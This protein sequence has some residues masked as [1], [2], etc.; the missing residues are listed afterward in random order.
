MKERESLFSVPRKVLESRR[1]LLFAIV[2]IA[3]QAVLVLTAGRRA[4]AAFGFHMFSE[5][6]TLVITLSREIDGQI[7]PVVDG[8]WS[9]KDQGGLSH[10]IR[11]YDRVKR[12][13]LGR[14]GV[15]MHASYGA[16]AQIERL[17]AAL[18]DVA[19]H[20]PEDAE[21]H[22]LLL[23]VVIRRNGHES[24]TVHLASKVR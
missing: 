22:R 19:A 18:E 10:R 23:D 6:S 17:S 4:D 12:T 21:T 9:A 13:E 11:W 3:L 1:Q 7:V 5:S 2:W 8:T 15:E 24:R 14:F 16:D 20:T